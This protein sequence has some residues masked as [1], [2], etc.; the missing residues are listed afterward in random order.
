MVLLVHIG[1]SGDTVSKDRKYIFNREDDTE[2]SFSS[3]EGFI[4]DDF[5]V[6][7]FM[8][9]ACRPILIDSLIDFRGHRVS[10]SAGKPSKA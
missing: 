2:F 8:V 1:Q 3:E 5:S 10:T 4:S 9:E 7:G 6:S